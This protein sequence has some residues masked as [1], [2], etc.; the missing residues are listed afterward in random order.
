MNPIDLVFALGSPL[1]AGASAVRGGL[2]EA[3]TLVALPESAPFAL[4]LHDTL[5]GPLRSLAGSDV[6]SGDIL[7]F[8]AVFFS[9][10]IGAAVV[11]E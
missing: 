7:A 6:L 11:A 8:A 1:S 4:A 3:A 2:R 5:R 9:A 10:R